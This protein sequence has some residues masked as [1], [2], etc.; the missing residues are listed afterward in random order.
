MERLYEGKKIV[1]VMQSLDLNNGVDA[2]SINMKNFHRAAF[3]IMF[4]ADL[5]GDFVLTV[6]SGASDAAKTTAETFKYTYGG[7]AIGSANC[8]VLEA[9]AES[10][11]LTCTG[12]TF[13]SR[14]LIVEIDAD[15]LTDDQP[16]LTLSFSN[17]GAAGKCTIFA[18]LDPRYTPFGGTSALV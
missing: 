17:A 18:L 16:W 10:A 4:G 12:T 6:N 15:K 14:M 5:S 8:D 1:P 7:A 9:V 2:D 11:A 3:L 13:V